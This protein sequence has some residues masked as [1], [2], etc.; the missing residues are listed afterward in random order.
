MRVYRQTDHRRR[1]ILWPGGLCGDRWWISVTRVKV[2][3]LKGLC[4]P[5]G[6]RGCA[7]VCSFYYRLDLL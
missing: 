2:T 7:R 6:G 1:R 5:A 4:G 3:Q